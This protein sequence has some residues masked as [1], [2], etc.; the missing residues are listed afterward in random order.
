MLNDIDYIQEVSPMYF[1]YSRELLIFYIQKTPLI[2]IL[3][4]D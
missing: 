2:Q 1:H 4:G 3:Q